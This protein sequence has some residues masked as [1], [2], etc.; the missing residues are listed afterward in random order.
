MPHYPHLGRIV[1][2]LLRGLVPRG[3][4][5]WGVCQVSACIE[6]DN[7][8]S[9]RKSRLSEWG[10]YGAEWG[11]GSVKNAPYVGEGLIGCD[12]SPPCPHIARG[13]VGGWGIALIGALVSS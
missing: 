8:H 4:D 5:R 13:G 7:G 3:G 12:K 10:I 11:F 9:P 1:G 2:L 6:M